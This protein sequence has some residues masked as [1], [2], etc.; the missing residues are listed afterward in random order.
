MS[1]LLSGIA[2]SLLGGAQR[3][4]T[5]QGGDLFGQLLQLATAPKPDAKAP[6]PGSAS[7]EAAPLL[8][9][10][11]TSAAS[12][13]KATQDI[14][15]RIAVSDRDKDG[16]YSYGDLNGTNLSSVP[17]TAK[18]IV[19]HVGANPQVKATFLGEFH[20]EQSDRL[21]AETLKQAKA[22]GQNPMLAVE[23]PTTPKLDGMI[24]D[25]YAGKMT[26][27]EFVKEGAKEMFRAYNEAKE[28]MGPVTDEQ[29]KDQVGLEYFEERL[30]NDVIKYHDQGI[31]V[32]FF[33]D[34]RFTPGANRDA[35]MASKL[36]KLV[37]DNPENEVYVQAG[38]IH[39]QEDG[40]FNLDQGDGQGV[41]KGVG[42]A[43]MDGKDAA[44]ERLAD[45]MGDD[46]VLST[47]LDQYGEYTKEDGEEWAGKPFMML[48]QQGIEEV[49]YEGVEGSGIRHGNFDYIV[50]TYDE[51]KYDPNSKA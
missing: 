14:L 4:D 12:G 31:K 35:T 40:A 11:G 29:K 20:N 43:R 25:L 13:G 7:S 46:A 16:E 41:W 33:D 36:E 18:A 17:E 44:A 42:T 38:L 24:E 30:K 2:S 22:A 28:T 26:Q 47:G 51:T 45:S 32:G 19:D 15:S 1:D 50:P 21:V 23:T 27:D 5:N 34:D 6:S 9:P 3:T 10:M 37:K 48:P 39:A 8:P 49:N